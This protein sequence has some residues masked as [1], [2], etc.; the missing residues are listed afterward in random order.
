VSPDPI[1]HRLSLVVRPTNHFSGEPVV[2][3][4]PVRLGTTFERPVRVPGERGRRQDDGAYRFVDLRSGAVRVLWREP[5]ARG[6]GPWVRWDDDPVV[7]LPLTDPASFVDLELWPAPHAEVAVSVTGVRGKLVGPAAVGQVVR[8]ALQAQPFD[9]FTR[10]DDHG[11]FL[12]LPPG[13]VPMNA[14]GRVPMTIAVRAP[15]GTPRIVTGG[16]FVP[17]AAGAPFA[18]ADFTLLPRVVSRVIFQ[19]A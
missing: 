4:L 3:E 15:D 12:F 1:R 6:H 16:S 8:I 19:I 13:P 17:A 18:G 2:D 5:F 11:D 7:T 10:S 9:R 14:A